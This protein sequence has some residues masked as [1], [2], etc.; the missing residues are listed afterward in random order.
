MARWLTRRRGHEIGVRP[1]YCRVRLLH[2]LLAAG[3]LGAALLSARAAGAPALELAAT[4]PLPGVE[5]RIDHLALDLARGRLFVAALGNGT[6]EVLDLGRN[7]DARSIA[8]FGEPQGLAYVPESN[9]LYVANGSANRV[10]VLDARTLA[11]RARIGGLEDAD[12]VRYD[13]AR[14][15]LLV[16]YGRGAIRVLDADTGA[17]EGDIVLPGHPEAFEP[18]PGG[19]RVFVNVPEARQVAVADFAQ[20]RVVAAWKLPGARANFPMALDAA[21]RRLFVG[22]RAPHVM[23]VYDTDSGAVVAKLPIG[24]DA[25]DIFYDAE[26]RR[27]YVVCGEGRVDVFRQE[28]AGRYAREGSVETAPRARTG[29]FVP[30]QRRLYVAAPAAGATPARVL[31]YRVQ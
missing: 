10:D 13:A 31:V 26:R 12:N 14:R 29:L 28:T 22:A 27:V 8:G 9:R 2:R 30:Q 25:D 21:G 7:V 16:G 19:G 5:G 15:R 3:A 18:E 4:I 20:R 1:R 6:L 23:L 11:P 24:R 17:P